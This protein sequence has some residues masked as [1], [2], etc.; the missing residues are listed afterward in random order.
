MEEPWTLMAGPSTDRVL[1]SHH[2]CDRPDGS[3]VASHLLTG[4]RSTRELNDKWGS[5]PESLVLPPR[6]GS[7]SPQLAKREV[8]D[9]RVAAL[10]A[11]VFAAPDLR[12]QGHRLVVVDGDARLDIEYEIADCSS[13][14][15]G[16]RAWARVV[17]IPTLPDRLPAVLEVSVQ[18]DSS[19]ILARAGS[20][21]IR[22]RRSNEEEVNALQRARPAQPLDHGH[23][24][25]L[26]AMDG[27]N[28]EDLGG[29][30]RMAALNNTNGAPVNRAT[31]LVSLGFGHNRRSEDTHSQHRAENQ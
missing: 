16:P 28:D 7:G 25:T 8:D 22:I 26:V 2:S 11:T 10:N 24:C 9:P 18:I 19:T 30:G 31:Y 1:L 4:H 29:A 23:P 3:C 17:G 12:D 20:R 15:L 21:P 14:G 6:R 5:A 27:S 13:L